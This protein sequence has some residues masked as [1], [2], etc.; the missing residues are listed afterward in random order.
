MGVD[1]ADYLT[2][3]EQVILDTLVKISLSREIEIVI[4]L[5]IKSWFGD[6]GLVQGTPF[7]ACCL[8]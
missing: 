1:Y 5:G 7:W 6:M 2:S 8:F 3:A 4:K